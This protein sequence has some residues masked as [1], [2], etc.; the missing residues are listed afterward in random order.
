MAR[1]CIKKG[2]RHPELGEH[3]DTSRIEKHFGWDIAAPAHIS[4]GRREWIV[5]SP[6]P[7]HMSA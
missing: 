4:L 1:I 5:G 2:R 3:G 6:E 7:I